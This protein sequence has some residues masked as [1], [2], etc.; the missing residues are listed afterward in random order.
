MRAGGGKDIGRQ[1]MAQHSP[2]GAQFPAGELPRGS[3]KSTSPGIVWPMAVSFW[4][5]SP[6]V[7]LAIVSCS[8]SL[9]PLTSSNR[10]SLVLLGHRLGHPIQSLHRGFLDLNHLLGSLG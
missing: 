7:P 6:A 1:E 8:R 10:L 9:R 5:Q 3:W 4:S 2:S